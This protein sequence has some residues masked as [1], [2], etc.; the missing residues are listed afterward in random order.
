VAGGENGGQRGQQARRAFAAPDA[1]ENISA[2]WLCIAAK[3]SADSSKIQ[4]FEAAIELQ[5]SEVVSV[6]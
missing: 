5:K 1:G 2:V 6:V 3:P 4:R